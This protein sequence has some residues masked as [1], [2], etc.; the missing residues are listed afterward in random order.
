[1]STRTKELLI[2]TLIG[3]ALGIVCMGDLSDNRTKEK[4]IE[5][6]CGEYNESTGEFNWIPKETK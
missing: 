6:G 2:V 1:M 4:A 3:F 5:Y